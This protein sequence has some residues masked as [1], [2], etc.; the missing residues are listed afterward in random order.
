MLATADAASVAVSVIVTADLFQPAPFGAGLLP[1]VVTG[2]VASRV[3]DVR[4]LSWPVQDR[5]LATTPYCTGPGTGAESVQERVG[6]TVVQICV[7]PTPVW[8]ST[9]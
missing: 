8:R 1:N 3:N 6:S 7:T 9:V 2:A 4:G 5:N